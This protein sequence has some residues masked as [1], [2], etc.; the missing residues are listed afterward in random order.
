G[1]ETNRKQKAIDMLRVA[2]IALTYNSVSKLGPLFDKALNSFL[3]QDY[4]DYAV[5]IV[6]NGSSDGTVRALSERCRGGRCTL[7]PLPRNCGWSCGNNRGAL[8]AK[9]FDYFYFVNDDVILPR[10]S[11]RRLVEF[12]ERNRDV[13]A[14]HPVIIEGGVAFYGFICGLGGFCKGLRRPI[15]RPF[16]PST[17]A[18]GSAFFTP[19]R[20]FFSVGMFP[21]DFFLY[22]DEVDYSWRVWKAGYKVGCLTTT[23]AYHK[24]GATLGGNPIAHY[25]DSANR[26]RSIVRNSPLHELPMRLSLSIAEH[27]VKYLGYHL[28]RG[29]LKTVREGVRGL[30]DGILSIGPSLRW[31]S[32][33]G[34]R[35]FQ[36]PLVDIRLL[37]PIKRVRKVL[38][39]LSS[40]LWWS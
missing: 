39:P 14:L 10:D 19:S 6:D 34:A 28:S 4:G 3:G 33:G 40:S 1:G 37:V 30:A 22:Y 38:I 2:L 26:I 32:A 20:V 12:A 7:L 35:A 24:G 18:A 8:L 11:V 23:W 5:V 16:S 31:R 9:D 27:A 36:S 17:F 13:G 15:G 25:Y 29:N 21:D